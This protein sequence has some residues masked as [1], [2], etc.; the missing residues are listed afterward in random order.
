MSLVDLFSVVI[1]PFTSSGI[2]MFF[3][4]FIILAVIVGYFLL[5]VLSILFLPLLDYFRVF[6]PVLF[7][8]SLEVIWVVGVSR[9]LLLSI[10]WKAF[11]SFSV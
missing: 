4:F 10:A 11:T 8:I 9:S 2:N 3:I 1:Y 5:V 6:I 7:C